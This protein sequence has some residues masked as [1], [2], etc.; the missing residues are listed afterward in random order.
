M[1][2]FSIILAIA[3]ML[4]S[5]GCRQQPKENST[6]GKTYCLD[7]IFAKSINTELPVEMPAVYALSLTGN[8]EANP[9]RVVQITSLV[10]GIV[11]Q[12][13]FTLGDLVTR[14]SVLAEFRSPEFSE[15][16]SSLQTVESQIRVAERKLLAA[17]T[18]YADNIA[19]K[20]DLLEAQSEVEIHRSE[21]S[22]WAI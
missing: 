16:R 13:N 2:Q 6:D 14:G 10:S 5:T 3:L 22:Y 11:S 7:S 9:D 4:I 8:V 17:Q 21:K 19:S 15:L 18:M 20:K 1:R 12:A